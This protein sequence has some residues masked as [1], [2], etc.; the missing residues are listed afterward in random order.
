MILT[1]ALIAAAVLVAGTAVLATAKPGYR[2]AGHTIS[3]LGEVGSPVQ[4]PAALLFAV[5]A[6]LTAVVAMAAWSEQAWVAVL[7]GSIAVAP[8]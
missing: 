7:A 2:H 3:E 4:R 5:V 1:L 8:S 6:V